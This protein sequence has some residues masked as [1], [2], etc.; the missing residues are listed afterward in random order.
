MSELAVIAQGQFIQAMKQGSSLSLPT[1]VVKV[2][3]GEGL[4]AS[5]SIEAR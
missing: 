3:A 1:R 2:S 4:I 5:G